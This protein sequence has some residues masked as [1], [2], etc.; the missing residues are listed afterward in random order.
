MEELFEL[1]LENMTMEYYEKRFIEILKY[2]GFIKDEKLKIQR[3]IDGILYSYKDN[4]QYDRLNTLKDTIWKVKHLY[5]H[6]MNTNPYQKNLK[7]K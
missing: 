1:K 3:F 5:D 6:N 4:I 7:Y 2:A